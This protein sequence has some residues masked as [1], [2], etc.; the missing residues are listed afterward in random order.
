MS[1]V[2]S[3][4]AARPHVTS[5]A[6]CVQC[7][8]KWVAVVPDLPGARDSLECPACGAMTDAAH[9]ARVTTAMEI[10]DDLREKVA[11]GQIVAF[12]AVGIEPDDSTRMWASCTAD[13]SRLRVI[14]AMSHMQHMYLHGE[15]SS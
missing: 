2:T 13:V 11:G 14:G 15:E 1:K 7:Q 4:D 12:A 6:C 10:I 9:H 3:L 5:P 8:H